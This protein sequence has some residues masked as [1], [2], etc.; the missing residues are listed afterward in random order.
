MKLILLAIPLLVLAVFLLQARYLQW[1]EKRFER[2]NITYRYSLLTLFSMFAAGIVGVLIL[3]LLNFASMWWVIFPLV[4]TFVIYL[5]ML[6]RKGQIPFMRAVAMWALVVIGSFVIATV[7]MIPV[8][9]NLIQHYYVVGPSMEPLILNHDY[10]LIDKYSRAYKRG[11][12]I[13]FSYSHIPSN[14]YVQR[15]IAV[16]GDTIMVN[17]GNVFINGQ[18]LK[19]VYVNEYT[20][21]NVNTMLG[22]GE[23][24]VMGDNRDQSLDSRQ[25]GPVKASGI[26]G[27]VVSH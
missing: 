13:V 20:E 8:R 15:I 7:V 12:V 25:M 27:K 10:V 5:F 23:Y 14:N 21:G 6:K 18:Q 22:S 11:D 4:L 9:K 3:A 2:E 24:F 26:H 17:D 1:L 16:P 19:E